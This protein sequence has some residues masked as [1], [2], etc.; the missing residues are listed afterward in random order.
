[1]VAV[2][3]ARMADGGQPLCSHPARQGKPRRAVGPRRLG[4]Q[5]GRSSR[6]SRPVDR[7]PGGGSGVGRSDDPVC[8]VDRCGRPRRSHGMGEQGQG[9]DRPRVGTAGGR[10]LRRLWRRR[11]SRRDRHPAPDLWQGR[12]LRRAGP[13]L[14]RL[15]HLRRP[16]GPRHRRRAVQGRA[17]ADGRQGPDRSERGDGHGRL[18]R[19]HRRFVRLAGG[20]RPGRDHRG[21]L[22]FHRPDPAQRLWL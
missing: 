18:D 16:V 17:Q 3:D 13:A 12:R 10:P 5:T 19:H 9:P 11:L 7:R 2:Q 6:A 1:M 4:H 20:Q 15:H 22:R 14:R 8:T 21:Q